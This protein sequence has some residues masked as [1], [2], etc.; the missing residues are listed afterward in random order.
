[1]ESNICPLC[2]SKISKGKI[3]ELE[4]K[5]EAQESKIKEDLESKFEKQKILDERKYKQELE[6]KFKQELTEKDSE[7]KELKERL[8]Q[9]ERNESEIK[10]D[11][12]KEIETGLIE[13][14]SGEMHEKDEKMLNLQKKNFEEQLR[15]TKELEELKRKLEHKIPSE[16]GGEG[17]LNVMDILNKQFPHD[18]ITETKPGKAG[19][20]IFHKIIDE[21]KCIGPIIYEVKNVSNW[22]NSFIDQVKRE[23][24]KHNADYAIL[25]SNVLPPKEQSICK[26]DDVLI[27]SPKLVGYI[28]EEIRSLLIRAHKAK[29][30]T[31]EIDEKMIDLRE[32]LTSAEYKNMVEHLNESVNK[33]RTIQNEE[34]RKHDLHWTEEEMLHKRIAQTASGIDSKISSILEGSLIKESEFE[35]KKKKKELD[36]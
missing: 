34:R 35:K 3:K 13:K 22:N 5:F 27:V 33:L 20:D 29:L 32:F 17:Q 31:E 30:S 2:G 7:F 14:Y 16:L 15:L 10:K 24:V 28:T 19:G 21:G 12:K 8:K 11:L 18:D 25:V 1:M 9:A 23:K 6:Q 4:S 36:V 26:K